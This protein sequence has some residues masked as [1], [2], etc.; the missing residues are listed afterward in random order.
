MTATNRWI[1]VRSC[2]GR[3]FD[4]RLTAQ[5]VAEAQS[6]ARYRSAA[7]TAGSA[8]AQA[9]RNWSHAVHVAKLARGDSHA[10]QREISLQPAKPAPATISKAMDLQY[11][12]EM[13]DPSHRHGSNLR[14]YHEYWKS[15]DSHENFFYW[16]D[17]GGGKNVELP[18][19]PR[20]KLS[21]EKVRYL[22][23]EERLNYL[24]KVDQRGRFRWARNNELVW[25]NN[26]LYEDGA[27]GISPIHAVSL[28]SKGSPD[29]RSRLKLRH[30]STPESFLDNETQDSDTESDPAHGLSSRR[31][32]IINS[33]KDKLFGKDDWW[34]FVRSHQD[35]SNVWI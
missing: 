2:T 18:E 29:A 30:G 22:S 34:I 33:I 14:K 6:Q 3:D 31:R 26:S 28:P 21:R 17:Y 15:T 24:V 32:Q 20:D 35:E 5:T 19:C 9:H 25:T 7:S 27:D 16:L 10:R 11:F 1:D 4:S 23:R 13:M 8:A 12:L